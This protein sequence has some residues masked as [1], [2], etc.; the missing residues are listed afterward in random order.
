[1]RIAYRDAKDFR[2]LTLSLIIQANQIIDLFESQGYVLTLRQLY[3]QLVSKNIIENSEREYKRLSK[4]MTDARYA[5]LISWNALEDRTREI[6]SLG[7]WNSPAEIIESA[8]ATFQHDLWRDQKNRVEVWV[9]KDALIGVLKPVCNRNDVAYFSCRGN[10]SASEMWVSAQRLI[11]HENEDQEC[12]VLYLGDHDPS[13]LDMSRDVQDRLREFE[14]NA[15]VIRL[16]L[17]LDQIALWRPPPQPAKRTDSRYKQYVRR[18]GQRLSWELDALDPATLSTLVEQAIVNLR[19]ESMWQSA[20]SE[21]E[22]QRELLNE[23]SDRWH[24]VVRYLKGS[25]KPD[26]EQDSES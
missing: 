11:A 19:D 18:T 16:A 8:A 12:W 3:Y 1:M 21:M 6:R 14:S 25:K 2:R 26:S 4:I 15:T 22:E 10:T 5:G 24:S 13:G 9:E 20:K 7:H 23:I 17:N